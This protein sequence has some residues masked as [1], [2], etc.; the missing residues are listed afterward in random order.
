MLNDYDFIIHFSFL[1]VNAVC[2]IQKSNYIC[3]ICRQF[4]ELT[5]QRWLWKKKNRWKKDWQAWIYIF[6]NI[7]I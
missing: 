3:G 7:V 5:C 6:A 4:P 1:E 2:I